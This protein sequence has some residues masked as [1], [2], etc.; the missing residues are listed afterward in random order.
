MTQYAYF[1]KP[2]EDSYRTFNETVANGAVNPA[3]LE[4]KEW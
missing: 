4:K 1:Y 3:V 2:D